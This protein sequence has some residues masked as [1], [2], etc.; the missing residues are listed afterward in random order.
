MLGLN[1]KIGGLILGREFV[2]RYRRFFDPRNWR[3]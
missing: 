1:K 3:R 2:L